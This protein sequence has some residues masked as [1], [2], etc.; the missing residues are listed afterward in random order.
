MKFCIRIGL[1]AVTNATNS[2]GINFQEMEVTLTV[3]MD[4]DFTAL[5]FGVAPN[6]QTNF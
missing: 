3:T 2:N 4:G 5:R 6:A 1:Y